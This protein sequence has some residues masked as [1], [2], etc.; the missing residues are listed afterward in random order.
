MKLYFITKDG[1]QGRVVRDLAFRLIALSGNAEKTMKM[2]D[3]LLGSTSWI[4]L[5][6]IKNDPSYGQYREL[7]E[8]KNLIAKYK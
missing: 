3:E 2:A 7:D 6:T 4:S 5:E 1:V 8:Y